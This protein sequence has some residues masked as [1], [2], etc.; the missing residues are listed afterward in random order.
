MVHF[1]WDSLRL[2]GSINITINNNSISNSKEFGVYL[3]RSDK[4]KI[5]NNTIEDVYEDGIY[6]NTSDDNTISNNEFK[7]ISKCKIFKYNSESDDVDLT[8]TNMPCHDTTA[9]CKCYGGF[10][11]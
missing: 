1:S 7:K 5:I 4:N 9:S 3:D 2:I 6:L 11:R 10:G 8:S